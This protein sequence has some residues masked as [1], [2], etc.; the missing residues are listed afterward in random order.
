MSTYKR[1]DRAFNAKLARMADARRVKNFH[2]SL[3]SDR[4]LPEAEDIISFILFIAGIWAFVQVV[5][6]RLLI[7]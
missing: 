2:P 6:L 3:N 1:I 7:R 5:D 4:Y